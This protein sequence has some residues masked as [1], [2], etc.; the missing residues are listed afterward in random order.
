[1]LNNT[2]S[3]YTYESLMDVVAAY[4]ICEQSIIK[5]NDY[6]TSFVDKITNDENDI[7]K[8]VQAQTQIISFLNDYDFKAGFQFDE[9]NKKVDSLLLLRANLAMMEEEVKNL[10]IMP[11]RYGSQKAIGICR[12][13]A[14]KCSESLKLE[15]AEAAALVESNTQ[16]LIAIRNQFESDNALLA[17]INKIIDENNKVLS[18]FKAYY[19]ELKKYVGEFPHSGDDLAEVN[20]RIEKVVMINTIWTRT[21]TVINKIENWANRNNKASVIKLYQSI[22]DDMTYRMLCSN[23]NSFKFK[24]EDIAK[25][26]QYVIDAFDEERQDLIDVFSEVSKRDSKMWKGDTENMIDKLNAWLKADTRTQ[27]LDLA[28]IKKEIKELIDRRK[29]DI[30]NTTITYPWLDNQWHIDFH[31]ALISRYISKAE[32]LRAV[33]DERVARLKKILKWSGITAGAIALITLIIKVPGLIVL[34]G[35]VGVII[36][37]IIRR[38][39]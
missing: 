25:Q 35:I 30:R 15:E 26:A 39:S 7:A 29:K 31:E 37:V 28:Q 36:Y 22:V 1:M 9:M 12:D 19:E 3:T 4:D 20:S 23:V 38:H 11:D 24:L 13:L 18:K 27:Q 6:V 32:Y 17:E 14:L 33:D 16:K 8:F 21:Q 2:T 10:S 34:G 5:D